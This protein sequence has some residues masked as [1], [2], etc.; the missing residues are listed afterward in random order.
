MQIPNPWLET[1]GPGGWGPAGPGQGGPPG[2]PP[3]D[4]GVRDFQEEVVGVGFEVVGAI[5]STKK[6]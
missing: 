6:N 1:F 4:Q 2:L 3:W 5:S